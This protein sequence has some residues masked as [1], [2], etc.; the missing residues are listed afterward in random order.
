[1]KARREIMPAVRKNWEREKSKAA[2]DPSLFSTRLV[3]I[4]SVCWCR[5]AVAVRSKS[6]NVASF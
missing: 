1:M 2:Y 4:Y 3:A 6:F 5:S